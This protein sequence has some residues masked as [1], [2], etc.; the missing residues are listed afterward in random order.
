KDPRPG[1]GGPVSRGPCGQQ[2]RG[3]RPAGPAGD[4]FVEATLDKKEAY[5]G[6]QVLLTYKLYTQVELA[7][8]PQ[9]RQL[10]GYTGFW[11]EEIPVDPRSTIRRTVVRGKEYLELTLMKKAIFPTK[12]GDLSIDETAF[13]I[14]VR[15]QSDDPFDSFF[16]PAQP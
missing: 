8:L 11:V 7:S 14:L 12:S 15:A 13:E 9:P 4:I 16:N 6:E 3:R 10:P 1:Q 5:V 2:Q